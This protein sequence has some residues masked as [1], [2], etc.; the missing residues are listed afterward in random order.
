MPTTLATGVRLGARGFAA[1]VEAGQLA[2]DRCEQIVDVIALQETLPKRLERGALFRSSFRLLRVPA[3]GQR[4]Q[5]VF[6]FLPLA[7]DR[8]PGRLET[9]PQLRPIGAGLP[10]VAD[11]VELL[12]EGK[13]FLEQPGRHLRGPRP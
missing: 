10:A 11:L 4:L 8:L 12:V 9:R 7:L 13:H 6:V 1:V 3:P 2:F 5:L